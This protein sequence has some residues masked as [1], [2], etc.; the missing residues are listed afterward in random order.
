[1]PVALALVATSAPLL[2]NLTA[3]S[4]GH[5]LATLQLF[6]GLT[7]LHVGDVTRPV[8]V[9]HLNAAFASL[10]SLADFRLSCGA[11]LASSYRHCAFPAALTGCAAL[12]RLSMSFNETARANFGALPDGLSRLCHLQYISCKACQVSIH[13]LVLHHLYHRITDIC[14]HEA[15]ASARWASQNVVLRTP[16]TQLR[17][18]DQPSRQ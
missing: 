15:V 5:N 1:M 9:A 3:E 14:Q 18:G 2:R 10:P 13:Q 7:L 11:P 4:G 8:N 12:T 17:A 16:R 6:K